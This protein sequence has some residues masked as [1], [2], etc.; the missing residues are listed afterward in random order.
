MFYIFSYFA[1]AV[2]FVLSI[3]N[4][5]LVGL[6]AGKLDAVYLESWKIFLSIV[7]DFIALNNV[8]YTVSE[9]FGNHLYCGPCLSLTPRS[10]V[11]SSPGPHVSPAKGYPRPCSME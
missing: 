1:I 10:F 9:D 11:S 3:V 2:A 7:V 5:F 6:M 4:W 8:S